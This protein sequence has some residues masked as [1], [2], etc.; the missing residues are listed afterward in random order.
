MQEGH[1]A[2][3]KLKK[4]KILH[5]ATKEERFFLFTFVLNY[6]STS[7]KYWLYARTCP[8]IFVKE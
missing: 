1:E 3:D 7:Y 5:E 4:I 2:E 6:I 8:D